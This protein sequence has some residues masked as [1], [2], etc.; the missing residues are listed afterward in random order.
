MSLFTI[1]QER[2]YNNSTNFTGDGST[3]AF[4]LTTAM[5]DPLPTAIGDIEI[6]VDGKQIS[7]GN[8]SYSSPTI[9]FSGNTNNS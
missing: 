7:I 9:T 2:Y 3:V 5:F 1:T 4:T 8:Y 6:F